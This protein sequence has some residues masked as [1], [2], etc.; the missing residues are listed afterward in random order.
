MET[1]ST[2]AVILARGGSKGLI[3]KNLRRVGDFSLLARSVLACKNAGVKSVFVSSDSKDI[4]EEAKR[5][6]ARSH[7]RSAFNSRD[8][9]SSE[10]AIVEFLEYLPL[11]DSNPEFIVFIQPTSPFLFS[12][13]IRNCIKNTV[14]GESTFTAY[15]TGKFVWQKTDNVWE[16]LGHDKYKRLRRQ[17][18]SEIVVENG[19]CYCFSLNDFLLSKSR[20]AEKTT[21]ILVP[22]FRSIEVDTLEELLEAQR[23]SLTLKC[24]WES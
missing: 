18:R 14:L 9:S 5:F 17:D 12:S 6:G 11:I 7:D 21:P 15:S 24:D 10:D 23:L 20:F 13:D 22:E 8:E 16:P 1:K 19:A 3:D 4:Q 2:C